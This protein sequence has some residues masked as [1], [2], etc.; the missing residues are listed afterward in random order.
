M[1]LG[2]DNPMSTYTKY[3]TSAIAF[4]SCL[5]HEFLLS[6]WEWVSLRLVVRLLWILRALLPFKV[7]PEH[8]QR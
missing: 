4:K 6:D 3:N 5:S 7:V 1:R 8:G 2:N